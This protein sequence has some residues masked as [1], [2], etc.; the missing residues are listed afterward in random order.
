[1]AGL[2]AAFGIVGLGGVGRTK[3]AQAA[4]GV[5]IADGRFDEIGLRV[6]AGIAGFRLIFQ[7][8][9]AHAGQRGAHRLQLGGV[10][11]QQDQRGRLFAVFVLLLRQGV[12][13]LPGGVFA[14]E[15]ID[16]RIGAGGAQQDRD[17][18]TRV[19]NTG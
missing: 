11:V 3:G 15:Q 6:L 1:M 14:A 2:G 16:R 18:L 9:R 10:G 17:V 12:D 19:A 7:F 8:F 13:I 4:V 5:D